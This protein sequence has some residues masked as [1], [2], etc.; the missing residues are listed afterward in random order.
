[1]HITPADFRRGFFKALAVKLGN[2][3]SAWGSGSVPTEQP[4]RKC[5]VSSSSRTQ[6]ASADSF[7]TSILLLLCRPM[8]WVESDDSCCRE[9]IYEYAAMSVVFLYVPIGMFLLICCTD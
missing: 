3:L 4:L 8:I 1:M 2:R 6:G 5:A 7:I 9:Y